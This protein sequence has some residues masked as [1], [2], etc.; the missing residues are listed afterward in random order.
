MTLNVNSRDTVVQIVLW[1]V[2]SGCLIHMTGDRTLLKNFIKKFIGTIR[3]RNDHFA[4]ITCYSD[5]VQGNITVCHVYY[6]EDLGHNLFSVGQFCDGDLEVAF[7]SKTYTA[8]SS[9]ICLMSKATSTKSWLWHR[10]HSHLNFGTINDLTKHDLVDGLLKFKYNKDH[11]CSA[12]EWGK[13]KKSSRQPKLFEKI[14]SKVSI[15]SVAQ[16]VHNHEDSPSTSLIIVK[17]H[18]GPPIVTTFQEQ[19]SPILIN[20]AN[21]LNQEDS[22]YFDGNTNKSDVDNIVI[23]NKSHFVAKGYKHEEGIDF[24]ESFAPVA[25]LESV[26]MFVAYAAQKNFTIFQMD[27]KTTFLNGPVKEDVY[28]SQ[29]DGFVNPY[30]PDRVY[31]STNPNFSK[32]FSN[33]M[34][35]NFEMS[36]MGELKFFL[37]LQVHQSPCSIF[38]TQSQYATKLLKKHGMDDCVLMSTPMAIERLDADLHGTPTDQTTC[39]Q[40]IRGLMYLTASR[41][42]I[43]FATFVCAHYQARP[44]VKHLKEVERIFWYL[45][46]SYNMG[47]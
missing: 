30:F 4:T 12:C 19:T 35:N 16:Q 1:I 36:I 45:R 40:K 24:E 39:H 17:E 32:R 2:N 34:R 31:R 37:G 46:Q 42:N 3:F 41:P 5:Y 8:A 26:R 11:L 10:K 6:V 13:S 44:M 33:L 27:V 47:L 23:R 7:C 25:R 14:S 15:N 18:E 28:V 20:K 9:A 22:T 38:I 21:E 43:A 29:P